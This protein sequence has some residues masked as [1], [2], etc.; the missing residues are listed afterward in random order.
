MGIKLTTPIEE[1]EFIHDVVIH[2]EMAEIVFP[3]N[4]GEYIHQMAFCIK[5]GH[6]NYDKLLDFV[7]GN[8]GLDKSKILDVSWIS[9]VSR[10]A[11]TMTDEGERGIEKNIIISNTTQ[12]K[13]IANYIV[14]SGYV[15]HFKL[16]NKGS[17]GLYEDVSIRNMAQRKTIY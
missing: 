4:Q 13:I 15:F 9:W 11:T 10:R 1:K 8:L 6:T 16:C 12:P 3:Q 14:N 17:T 2:A 7:I 5:N